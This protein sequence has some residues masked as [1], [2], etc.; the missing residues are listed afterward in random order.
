[1]PAASSAGTLVATSPSLLA[2]SAGESS[3]HPSPSPSNFVAPCPRVAEASPLLDSPGAPSPQP[4]PPPPLPPPEFPEPEPLKHAF[5]SK[6]FLQCLK[7][8][9]PERL[10]EVTESLNA[11]REAEVQ[12]RRARKD[13]ET[14]SLQL[15]PSRQRAAFKV[16]YKLA[17]GMRYQAWRAAAGTDAVSHIKD[18]CLLERCL[19]IVV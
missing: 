4:L 6:S 7:E 2:P 17:V 16:N 8:M 3:L 11:F 19:A 9:S 14:A 5:G 18:G 15:K 12:W 13:H 10:M 1:M